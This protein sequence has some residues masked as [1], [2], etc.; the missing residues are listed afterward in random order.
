ME[1]NMKIES[2]YMEAQTTSMQATC[3]SL[4]VN[5]PGSAR[6]I[7]NEEL[8]CVE[9]CSSKYLELFFTAAKELKHISK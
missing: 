3:F 1:Y 7:T 5:S 6:D 4:C 8:A 2:E 9:K